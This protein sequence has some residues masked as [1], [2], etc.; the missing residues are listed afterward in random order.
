MGRIAIV[1][2]S[3]VATSE[4]AIVRDVKVDP[5]GG[6]LE[7]VHLVG[8]AGVDAPPLDGDYLAYEDCGGVA[9]SLGSFDPKLELVAEKGEIRLTARSA[10]GVVESEVFIRKDKSVLVKNESGELELLA[11]GD[12]RISKNLL[13]DG[14]V[15]AKA[16]TTPVKL[17]THL[18]PTATGPSGAPIPGT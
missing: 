7:T 6:D 12:V 2:D 16:G 4:G 18:H 17:S 3:E 14:E 13:V 9:T 15:T 8:A 10:I 11:S 1:L 5:G